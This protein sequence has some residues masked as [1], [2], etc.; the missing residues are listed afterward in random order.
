MK[1]IQR[2]LIGPI[3]LVLA[4]A[5]VP[6][7]ANTSIYSDKA[8]FLSGSGATA[9]SGAYLDVGRVPNDTLSM[10]S[11]TITL[12]AGATQ[13]FS[14]TGGSSGTV[15]EDWT[16]LLPGADLAISGPEN[17]DIALAAPVFSFGYDIVEPELGPNI[18]APFVDSSFT[19]TLSLAGTTVA[20]FSFNPANDTAAFIG[21]WSDSPFDRVSIVETTPLSGGENEFYGRFFTGTIALP[22]PPIPEPGTW[23]MLAGGLGLLALLRRRR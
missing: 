21:I 4:T 8:S 18:N 12:G 16:T 22:P 7:F 17:L 23:A 19:V 15:N 20:S 6:V 2:G 5:S 10:G 9:A 13:L 3:G 11:L 1:T 14:G